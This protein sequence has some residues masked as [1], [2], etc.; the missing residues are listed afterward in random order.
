[1]NLTEKLQVGP[2]YFSSEQVIGD[3]KM[4][5]VRDIFSGVKSLFTMK[6]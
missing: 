4:S 5:D 6:E 3:V 1:M 2:I